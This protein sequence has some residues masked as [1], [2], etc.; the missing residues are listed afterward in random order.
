MRRTYPHFPALLFLAGCLVTLLSAPALTAR[1]N[2]PAAPLQQVTATPQPD[3][4]IIHTVQEGESAWTVAS[5]YG[6]TVQQLSAM[7]GLS[8]DPALFPGQ[9]LT[10]R[11]AASPTVTPTVTN[12][13]RPPTRTPAPTRTPRPPT[14]IPSETPIP[15]STPFSLINA[16]PTLEGA[17]RRNLG[18]GLVVVSGLG[19]LAIAASAIFRRG[20]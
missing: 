6:I 18:I 14:A 20:R 17:S 16:L 1:A 2:P 19:L 8:P 7:N 3:G 15:T 11:Q 13:A 4:S 9:T 12:T 10:V 5:L